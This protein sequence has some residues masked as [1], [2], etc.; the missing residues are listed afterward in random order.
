MFT[1]VFVNIRCEMVQR[2]KLVKRNRETMF[3]I[4]M[5]GMKRALRIRNQGHGERHCDD[6]EISELEQRTSTIKHAK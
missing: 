2:K 5:E 1:S 6:S 4:I 3:G